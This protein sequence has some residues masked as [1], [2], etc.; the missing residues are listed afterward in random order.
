M[1]LQRVEREGTFVLKPANL[2]EIALARIPYRKC[3][4]LT[5]KNL[6]ADNCSFCISINA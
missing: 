2:A 6:E 1:S 4:Q 3:E 5:L